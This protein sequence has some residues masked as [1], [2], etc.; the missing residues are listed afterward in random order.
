MLQHSGSQRQ[1]VY[2]QPRPAPLIAA[3]PAW[4]QHEV[5]EL[6]TLHCPRGCNTE[7]LSCWW[8][9][10][11]CFCT[12]SHRS[13]SPAACT[14]SRHACRSLDHLP[15]ALCSLLSPPAQVAF[16][17]GEL[18]HPNILRETGELCALVIKES[19]GPVSHSRASTCD[20]S[21]ASS[22][23]CGFCKLD[24]LAAL[25]LCAVAYRCSR[26]SASACPMCLFTFVSHVQVKNTGDLAKMLMAFLEV[27]PL[28][29]P[30]L[31]LAHAAAPHPLRCFSGHTV[32]PAPASVAD[33]FAPHPS[34]LPS[35]CALPIPPLRCRRP[36]WA[37]LWTAR[38][39]LSA[40]PILLSMRPLLP[41]PRPRPP[42]LK[43]KR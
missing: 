43:L 6:K 42:R 27:R 19:W 21:Q 35:T 37:T 20:P 3:W 14:A 36:T 38:L 25:S 10:V 41:Q 1:A 9:P 5:P 31:A 24:A 4:L 34:S 13:T 11:M 22:C 26:I 17:P 7:C 28:I 8:A 15:R 12:A 16:K 2:R 33:A 29:R 30:A 23:C 32:A 40:P 39:Q 18:L